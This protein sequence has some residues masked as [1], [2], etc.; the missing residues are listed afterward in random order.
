MS[1]PCSSVLEL[2]DQICDRYEVARLAR[3]RCRWP[4]GW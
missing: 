2:I 1:A 4:S 3:R